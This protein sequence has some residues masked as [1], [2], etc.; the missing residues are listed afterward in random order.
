MAIDFVI[1]NARMAGLTEPTDIAFEAGRVAAI[2]PRFVCDAPQ[3][4]STIV[5]SFS[6]GDV[7]IALPSASTSRT[8]P[9]TL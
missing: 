3:R 6:C 9:V 4:Q 1:R 2:A 8:G 5:P 7:S